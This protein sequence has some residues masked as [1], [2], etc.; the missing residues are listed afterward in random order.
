M[1]GW[2]LRGVIDRV[3][4]PD[5]AGGAHV[6]VDYKTGAAAPAS[7][8]RRDLQL[9]LYAYGAH[10][11]L[12]LEPLELEIV[13]LREGRAVRLPASAALLEAAAATAHGVAGEIAAGR[14]PAQPEPRRCRSCAYRLA[15]DAAL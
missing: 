13:Y 3:D 15:C 11:E 10:A 12:G 6:L 1:G 5:S 8:L 14:F 7:Q 9:A 4:A 2:Q